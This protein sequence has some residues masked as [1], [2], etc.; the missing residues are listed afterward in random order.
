MYS[1]KEEEDLLWKLS[2]LAIYC[3]EVPAWRADGSFGYKHATYLLSQT[4]SFQLAGKSGFQS[5]EKL[6]FLTSNGQ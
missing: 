1:Y 2:S 6:Y 5:L 4:E 3:V